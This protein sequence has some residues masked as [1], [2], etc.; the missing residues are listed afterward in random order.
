MKTGSD[1]AGGGSDTRM[2]ALMVQV[3]DLTTASGD[4]A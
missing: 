2:K 1:H 4:V 3:R